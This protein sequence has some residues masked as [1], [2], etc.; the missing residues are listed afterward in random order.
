M[1]ADEEPDKFERDRLDADRL[2]NDALTAFDRAVAASAGRPL[3]RDDFDR[4]THALIA[5]LQQITAFIDTKDRALAA[6]LRTRVDALDALRA[7]TDEVATRVNVLQRAVGS[8]Q[9]S[10]GSRQ[11]AVDRPP[12]TAESR[13]PNPESRQ[14]VV[15]VAFEDAFRGSDEAVAAK[16]AAY[17]PLFAGARDVVDLGC[18]RGEFLA[19]LSAAGISARGVDT[20]GEMVAIARERGLDVRQG[21]ALGFV[22]ALEDESIGGAIATQVIEHLEP[23]Y[24]VRLLEA[25]ARKLRPGA[26][27]VLETINPACWLAFFSSYIRDF[28]HV[29]PMHPETVQYLLRA[30]GFER[31]EIRY[32]APV[33][34]QVKLRTIDLPADV[35]AGADATSATLAQ[36]GHAINANAMAL[37]NLLF[38]HMDYAAVGYRA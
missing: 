1:G 21:D 23:S 11:S 25:L 9:E 31:V 27:L 34:E 6:T 13:I 30:V 16:L 18:G 29:R 20:N 15:Y 22:S 36:L 10:V 3:E 19:A 8:R 37:N 2:Y 38:T 14:D 7:R 35:L 4:I 28:T 17:V 33:P 26:P 5:F 32:S 12:S 24:L